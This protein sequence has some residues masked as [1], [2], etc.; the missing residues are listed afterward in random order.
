MVLV[1]VGESS[2]LGVI[3]SLCRKLTS[4][5]NVE[6]VFLLGDCKPRQLLV[7][8]VDCRIILKCVMEEGCDLD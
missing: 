3:V 4:V 1:L 5:K 2:N 6:R 7:A 8:C